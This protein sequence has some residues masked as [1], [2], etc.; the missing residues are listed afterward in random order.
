MGEKEN[1][2]LLRTVIVIGLIAMIAV[3]IALGVINLKAKLTNN[4]TNILQTTSKGTT[5]KDIDFT[6]TG[7]NGQLD[8]VV[9]HT[10]LVDKGYFSNVVSGNDKDN[11]TSFKF[12]AYGP[13]ASYGM[14]AELYLNGREINYIFGNS[15][16]DYL[17]LSVDYTITNARSLSFAE[18]KTL[19]LDTQSS[20]NFSGLKLG[21]RS[22]EF[23]WKQNTIINLNGD[24]S[25][26]LTLQAPKSTTGATFEAYVI[27]ANT[28]FDSVKITNLRLSNATH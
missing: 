10:N 24:K 7:T 23:G 2:G 3:I 6:M 13:G 16:S 9:S 20:D 26:T 19:N 8:K 4:Q 12:P 17:E 18:A 15:N 25:G 14:K 28:N 5:Q 22:D 27:L 21:L 1:G 11:D